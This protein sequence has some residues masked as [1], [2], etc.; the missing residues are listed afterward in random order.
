MAEGL[1][2]EGSPTTMSNRRPKMRTSTLM[3][4]SS[5]R[6]GS[7]GEANLSVKNSYQTAYIDYGEKETA[8][9]LRSQAKR[10]VSEVFPVYQK[11]GNEN[12]EQDGNDHDKSPPMLVK[13]SPMRKLVFLP[14]L[15][16]E[17]TAITTPVSK[18]IMPTLPRTKP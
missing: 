3:R 16:R 2:G 8:V 1:R 11:I 10:A 13:K 17:T 7:P 4:I 5:N 18:R 12:D 14:D 9:V 6:T 15:K